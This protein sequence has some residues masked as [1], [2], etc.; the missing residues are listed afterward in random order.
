MPTHFFITGIDTDIGKTY[1]TGQLLRTLLAQ[2]QLASS[3]KL[4]QTG[5]AV[6]AEDII[7]HRKL[8]QVALSDMDL[9]GDSC[10]ICLPYPASP[11]LAAKL[12]KTRISPQT[13]QQ[14]WQTFAAAHPNHMLFCEGAGGVFVPITSNYLIIDYLRDYP[15]PLLL[16]SSAKL[17]SIHHTIA[18]L[19]ALLARNQL[20][21][22]LIYNPYPNTAIICQ[23]S[24]AYLRQRVQK[25]YPSCAFFT[26]EE[27]QQTQNL[28]Q[29]L[30][31]L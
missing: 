24:E 26:L 19:E 14:R 11:H 1:I 17:G 25:Y 18:T 29:C 31:H 23:D 2:G 27:L 15:L 6:P 13:L 16:V 20:P 10:G 5:S 3:F 28:A 21:Q 7:A 22:A 8:S 12:A 4:I 9:Q 30:A